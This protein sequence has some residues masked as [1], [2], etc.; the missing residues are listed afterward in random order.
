MRFRAEEFLSG[1]R[2]RL[3]YLVPASRRND[4]SLSL[5]FPEDRGYKGKSAIADTR[6]TCATQSG[7]N[8]LRQNQFSPAL[9]QNIVNLIEGVADHH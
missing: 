3:A 1:Q 6:D 7:G 5:S 9:A 2:T 8:L 4:L